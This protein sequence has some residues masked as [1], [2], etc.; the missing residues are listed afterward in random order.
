MNNS[1]VRHK[2]DFQHPDEYK[3]LIDSPNYIYAIND[4]KAQELSARKLI[5]NSVI[6]LLIH[7]EQD[8]KPIML[9]TNIT[10]SISRWN[11]SDAP[12]SCSLEILLAKD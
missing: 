7:H 3:Q 6:G 12:G 9:S 1:T 8:H 11:D 10:N 2:T 5:E 4:N